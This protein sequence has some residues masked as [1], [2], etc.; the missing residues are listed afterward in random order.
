MTVQRGMTL[1]DVLVGSAL[2]LIV[3]LT[4]LGLLRASLL[5]SSSSKAKAGATAVATT[6]MEYLRSLPYASV[7]T[8]GGIPAGN[9]PQTATTTMNGI[10][11][12]I[13]TF[14][15]YV[16][17]VKDGTGVSDSN[18]ITTDYK[19]AKVAVTYVF[20]ETVRE[21]ALISNIAPPSIETTAGGG[22]LRV[23]VVDAVGV[24]VSGASVRIQNTS[25]APTVD[26]TTFSD[27]SGAATFPGAPTS[28]EYQISVTKSGYSSA[29]T[30]VR[31]ATNQNPT[32]GYLTVVGDQTTS[33]TFSID[34]LVPFTLRTLYPIRSASQS[35]TFS[36]SAGLLSMTNTQVS[37]GALQLAGS[38]G[39]YAASGSAR[40]TTTTPAY[41]SA[42]TNVSGALTAD[43]GTTVRVHVGDA[44]GVLIP[45][46]VLS[47]N[48]TGFSAFP[49][50]LSTVS[51]STYPSL[52]LVTELTTNN[53]SSTPEIL[54]WGFVYDE[55]PIPVPDVPFT[56]TGAKKKGTTGEG[57]AIYKTIVS[58]TT[59]ATGARYIPI[60]WD[61]YTLSEVTGYT[62]SSSS[63]ASPYTLTPGVPFD[64]SLFLE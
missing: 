24:P 9:I 19:K 5:I 46:A 39:S 11:Y 25:L 38:V 59:D 60:E 29:E 8:V 34:A 18:G 52:T 20:R 53:A 32:P 3:F 1:I 63:V 64:V 27:V 45:D 7:G 17:D 37:G 41:L 57:A 12:T 50:S 21:V 49:I 51:T 55:G 28:T 56:L 33:G 44:D 13:R 2:V 47:G 26:V 31:D 61:V 22:T 40:S 16:D 35:D 58:T 62:V 36:G 4:L 6:Q 30:Y 10:P 43:T 42:W 14:V 48:A 23:N 15:A 54:E